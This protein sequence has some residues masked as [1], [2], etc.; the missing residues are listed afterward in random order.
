MVE[1]RKYME[2]IK[3]I[4]DSLR[5][6][7]QPFVFKS[8]DTSLHVFIRNKL[9]KASSDPPYQDPYKVVARPHEL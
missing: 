8:L 3:P 6:N 4:P 9:V 5:C 1:F 2:F 7:L